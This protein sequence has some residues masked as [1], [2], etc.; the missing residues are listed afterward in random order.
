MQKKGEG[1]AKEEQRMSSE[2]QEAGKP[3]GGKTGGG[4]EIRTRFMNRQLSAN[5]TMLSLEILL[6]LEMLR[7][8]NLLQLSAMAKMEAS[9]ICS[10][11]ETSRAR[12]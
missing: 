4:Q 10:S 2:Y 12:R 9:V 7:P 6:Q 5:F 1:N 8:C 11:P 3:S